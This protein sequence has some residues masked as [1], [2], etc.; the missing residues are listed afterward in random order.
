MKG[1]RGF[2]LIEAVVVVGIAAM[3]AGTLVLALAGAAKFGARAGG[4]HRTAAL[5][6]A[7]QTLRIAQDAWK[8]G[9]PGS[10]PAGTA[11]VSIP[12]AGPEATATTMPARISA[13]IGD[14]GGTGASL[15]ITVSYP[16]DSGHADT[17][18]VT[19]SG[20]LRAIAPL[21]GSQVERP[22]LIAQPGI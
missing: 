16:P 11:G 13:T 5:L 12:V 14:A 6:F 4:P 20:P 22:G 2:A 1:Q 9:P 10:A 21:P 8:Y 15:S 18:S 7:R 17:G 3:C 19:L